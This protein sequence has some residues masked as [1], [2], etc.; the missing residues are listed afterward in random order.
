MD[1]LGSFFHPLWRVPVEGRPAA[2]PEGGLVGQNISM[3]HL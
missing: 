3:V 1:V 2:A